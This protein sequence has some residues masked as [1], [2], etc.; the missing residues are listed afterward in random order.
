MTVKM[1]E[2]QI[3][4][5]HI[6]TQHAKLAA[7]EFLKQKIKTNNYIS[8]VTEPYL[9][10]KIISGYSDPSTDVLGLP[11][12]RAALVISKILNPWSALQYCSRDMHTAYID[13]LGCFV[14]CAYFDI[15]HPINDSL[16]MLTLLSN[17]C[18]TKKNPPTNMRRH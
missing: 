1:T 5:E 12:A 13:V 4:V 7:I 3:I 6:N 10:K 17:H 15:L 11:E 9:I 8:C 2:N 18:N 14:V 16:E